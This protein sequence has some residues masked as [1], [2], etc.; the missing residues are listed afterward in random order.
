MTNQKKMV[1]N[2]MTKG[3]PNG[4]PDIGLGIGLVLDLVLGLVKKA[5]FLFLAF[6]LYLFC[7][8]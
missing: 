8:R 2:G 7:Y 3:K 1:T 5:R 4:N 6:F